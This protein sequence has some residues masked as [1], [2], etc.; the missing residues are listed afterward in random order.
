MQL[1]DIDDFYTVFMD[2]TFMEK[3]L[4]VMVSSV[5]MAGPPG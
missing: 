1:L 5:A 2:Q 4:K 3:T